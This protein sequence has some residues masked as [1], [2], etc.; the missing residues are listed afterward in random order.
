M[1]VDHST[2]F[3][4]AVVRRSDRPGEAFTEFRIGIGSMPWLADHRVQGIP[5]LPGSLYV[6]LARSIE[7]ELCG[8]A[9]QIVRN[10]SFDRPIIVSQRDLTVRAIVREHAD[11][12]VDYLF[13]EVRI[14]ERPE[15]A[16][17]AGPAVRLEIMP[18]AAAVSTGGLAIERVQAEADEV[19]EADRLYAQLRANGNDYGPAFQ[20]IRSVWHAGSRSLGR[21]SI[22]PA[23]G[24]GG[25]HPSLLDSMVQLLIALAARNGKTC[26]LRSIGQI[27]LPEG[28]LP[29]SLWALA[30]LRDGAAGDRLLGDVQAFDRSGNRRLQLSGIE[31]SLMERPEVGDSVGDSSAATKVVIAANFTAEPV[32]DTLKFW[33]NHLSAPIDADFAPY[34]QVFPQLLDP[35]STFH[36][37]RDGINMILLRLE[38]WARRDRPEHLHLAPDR[39]EQCFGSLAQHV[40][41]NGLRIAHWKR[42]ETEYLYRE[43]FE[44]ECYLRNGIRLPDDATVIDVGANIGLFSLF[45]MSRCSKPTIYAFE[46]APEIYDILRANL[47]AYGANGMPINAGV[48][49]RDG[50]A[51]FTFYENSS[52][53]SGFHADESA[54]GKALRA[55]VGSTLRGATSL[56]GDSFDRQVDELTADRLRSKAYECQLT[57]LSSLIREHQ[58]QRVDL[59]KVDAEKSE[60]GVLLGIDDAD[61]PRIHQVV[62]EVH[63]RSEQTLQSLRDLLRQKGFQC[64]VERERL[65][66]NSGFL[67]LYAIRQEAQA[68]RNAGNPT[69]QHTGLQRNVEDFCAALEAFRQRNP[70][71]LV[72]CVCPRTALTGREATIPQSLEAAEEQVL[73]AANALPNVRAIS[74]TSLVERYSLKD[75]YDPHG[76]QLGDIPYSPAGY[77]A[78]G[79]AV[80]RA[81]RSFSG[82]PFK[83]I[84]LDCD[85]TLWR[86]TCGEDGSQGVVLD[87]PYLHLQRFMREQ[88]RAGMLLCLCSKNNEK[89]VLEVLE[90]RPDMVLKREHLAAWR[91]NWDRKSSNLA[92]LAAELNLG[93][94]SFIFIDDNPLDCADVRVHCPQALTLQLPGDSQSIP[95]FLDHS[96]AFDRSGETEE[97]RNRT[98]MVREG[99]DREKFRSTAGSLRGFIDGLELRV[100]IDD[101]TPDQIARISQ[102]TFRT[103][104]FNFT[105]I[106]RNERE[107]QEFLAQEDAACMVVR[108]TDRFGEYGLVGVVLYMITS[109]RYQVDTLL[110]SCR[111]LGRGVEHAMLSELARRAAAQGKRLLELHYRPT[112]RNAPARLFLDSIEGAKRPGVAPSRIFL[113]EHLIGLRYDPDAAS[114]RP[115][116]RSTGTERHVSAAG[117]GTE[118]S[119][120]ARGLE[121]IA[122]SLRSA[123]SVAAAMDEVAARDA[124]SDVPDRIPPA[125]SMDAALL[126]IW[127]RVLGRPRIDMHDNFFDA[128]GTSLKAVQILAM[129]RKELDRELS[130][131]TMFE[132]PTVATLA[133]RLAG[134][135]APP[136]RSETA[137]SRGNRRRAALAREAA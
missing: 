88:Q 95:A 119:I 97:D 112:D 16:T 72:L 49:D 46:P 54:D 127:R 125:K 28:D 84:V 65:L 61:W 69:T 128:G 63:D 136:I 33:G 35:G 101:A 122:E 52:V 96:W 7:H 59:L 34:N 121:R 103:N 22:P 43:I 86:G 60:L 129:I 50:T 10:L 134:R 93:F 76:D 74:S 29:D 80:C 135:P 44:D 113:T 111:V 57:S 73:L 4:P 6:E 94:E 8:R 70:T 2:L 131:V 11:G 41:P 78:I 75:Y 14:R 117:R 19:V 118:A 92:A 85:N 82:S 24:N 109:D 39:A 99:A 132:C 17:L 107:I 62:V 79:T 45:V 40:L 106:R 123:D 66:E 110:L 42:H 9:P 38:A 104:Q 48:A 47:A 115:G 81:I 137:A 67:N 91:I 89:D 37:N 20:R 1:S 108:V 58:I 25:L 114:T 51:R 68:G 100:Q 5:I 36:G 21:I 27:E 18:D 32:E 56:E 87:A 77:V 90:Q 120:A 55:I 12:H 3:S 126:R 130:I 64:S 124:S 83:V 102:L 116:D 30:E 23:R 15:A 31:L 133:A 105:T 98:R 13:D 26:V 71:P 53:F